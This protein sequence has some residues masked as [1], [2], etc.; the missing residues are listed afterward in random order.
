M[1]SSMVVDPTLTAIALM[2][3]TPVLLKGVSVMITGGLLL[4]PL[5]IVLYHKT[6]N[7]HKEEEG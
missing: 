4:T 7:E 3:F 6:I 5:L 1:I 2:H